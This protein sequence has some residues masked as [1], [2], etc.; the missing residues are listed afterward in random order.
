MPWW[1]IHFCCS[2]SL[3]RLRLLPYK[4]EGK[5]STCII[6]GLSNI[7]MAMAG[8]CGHYQSA[9]G[10]EAAKVDILSAVQI[11]G[12]D[13]SFWRYKVCADIRSGL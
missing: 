6:F 2:G 4:W 12:R 5:I 3:G 8:A 13:S 9:G 1:S 11:F 10:L 7:K